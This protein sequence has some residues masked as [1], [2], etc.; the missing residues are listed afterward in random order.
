MTTIDPAGPGA[1]PGRAVRARGGGVARMI[2]PLRRAGRDSVQAALEPLIAAHRAAYP[3]A[4]VHELR[5]A[6]VVAE[7]MHRGQPRKSGAPY[8]THPLA[9]AMILASLG[10]DGVTLVAALL[11]DTVED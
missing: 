5:R 7:R 8:I 11:H 3:H 6:Y 10:M 2:P 9:V 1:R 4:D